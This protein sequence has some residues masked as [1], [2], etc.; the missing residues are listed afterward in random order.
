MKRFL[1]LFLSVLILFPIVH[2]SCV[3]RSYLRADYY[4]NFGGYQVWPYTAHQPSVINITNQP[5]EV[6]PAFNVKVD[7]T[8]TAD[9]LWSWLKLALTI[10]LTCA[11]LNMCWPVI[12]FF[13]GLS[14]PF[15]TAKNWGGNAIKWVKEVWTEGEEM[16]VNDK[17]ANMEGSLKVDN[18][19]TV[20]V[21]TSNLANESDSPTSVLGLISVANRVVSARK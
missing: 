1:S 13:T 16:A 11:A 8:T 17:T 6:K 12:K 9:K 4:N 19:E 2:K 21:Y 14:N 10:C 20:H 7:G 3:A 5:P 18:G 15:D